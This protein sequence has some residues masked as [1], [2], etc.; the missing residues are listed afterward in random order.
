MAGPLRF[1]ETSA[2]INK[3]ILDGEVKI[4]LTGDTVSP[5]TLM[6]GVVAHSSMGQ[7]IT[8]T[9]TPVLYG[10]AQN[11]T[12]AQKKQ[13][14]QNIGVDP[15]S[16][17]SNFLKK[18]GDTGSGYFVFCKDETSE[19]GGI[20]I[21][22]G[23]PDQYT[24]E[25]SS[26]LDQVIAEYGTVFF[27]DGEEIKALHIIV[28]RGPNSDETDD[29]M[30]EY[31]ILTQPRTKTVNSV[32]DGL[33]RNVYITGTHEEEN[34]E[35]SFIQESWM[36]QPY[37][38]PY[39]DADGKIPVSLSSDLLQKPVLLWTNASPTSTFAPQDITISDE[40]QLVL[41]VGTCG[42]FLVDTSGYGGNITEMHW[43]SISNK[44]HVTFQARMC[45]RPGG[46]KLT[47][48][49]AIGYDYNYSDNKLTAKQDNTECIPYQIWGIKYN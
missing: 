37:G 30:S 32:E 47:I 16:L 13:A 20:V 26:G 2:S 24:G 22:N 34:Y 15:D 18:T 6:E 27:S 48:G 31:Y 11:L 1:P 5:E 28:N 41:V 38:I 10:K 45:T 4:D 25:T 43:R 3:V 19:N 7:N 9:M 46:N 44:T 8:G 12:E 23:T 29:Q 40:Y 49:N 17:G 39:L 21:F 36:G 33:F 14:Q 42:G 35:D